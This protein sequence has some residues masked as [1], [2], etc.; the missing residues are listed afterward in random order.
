[1]RI[2][3]I[4][5]ATLTIKA[6]QLVEVD[7]KQAALAIKLRLAVPEKKPVKKK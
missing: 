5:D 6:G 7:P 3:I 1:M 4:K 2:E